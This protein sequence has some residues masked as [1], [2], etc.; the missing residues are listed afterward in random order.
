MQILQQFYRNIHNL[1]HFSPN[2]YWTSGQAVLNYQTA[3]FFLQSYHHVLTIYDTLLTLLIGT[4][5]RQW[6]NSAIIQDLIGSLP[7]W[8]IEV[9]VL[10]YFAELPPMKSPTLIF[11]NMLGN[12]CNF[13]GRLQMEKPRVLVC[14]CHGGWEAMV[15]SVFSNYSQMFSLFC[16]PAFRSLFIV[17]THIAC[18]KVVL[19][20]PP[21]DVISNTRFV[22]A[23]II[24]QF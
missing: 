14:K 18:A 13:R 4:D 15:L 11:K 24:I 21:H 23:N 16:C 7:K 12:F 1:T 17:Y 20:F 6:L 3:S 10:F 8:R 9:A 2:L 22:D 19:A 5:C